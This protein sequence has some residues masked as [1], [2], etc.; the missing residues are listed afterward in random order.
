MSSEMCDKKENLFLNIFR[1]S[2]G[3][4]KAQE[5]GFA[6]G[7]AMALPAEPPTEPLLGRYIFY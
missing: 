2:H 4:Q 1:K 5:S 3:S 7:V 6:G